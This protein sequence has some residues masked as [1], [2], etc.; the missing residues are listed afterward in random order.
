MDYVKL[1][2][3][4]TDVSR[5]CLG[6]MTFGVPDRGTHPWTL[7][8]ETTRDL[9]SGTLDLGVHCVTLETPLM[10]RDRKLGLLRFQR[11]ESNYVADFAFLL[12][13]RGGVWKAEPW[14][15]V[16]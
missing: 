4:G 13:D 1:G 12:R 7:D 15:I 3:T 6:C 11:L 10:S 9:Q 8:E 14:E 5:L 16:P 2:H